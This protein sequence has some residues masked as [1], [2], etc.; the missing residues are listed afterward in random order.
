MGWRSRAWAA[1]LNLI[2]R[3][4]HAFITRTVGAV[5]PVGA[6]GDVGEPMA[7]GAPATSWSAHG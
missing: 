1:T 7:A 3:R 2:A 6:R 5:E 4:Q